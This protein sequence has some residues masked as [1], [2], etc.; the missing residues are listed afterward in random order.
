MSAACS[1]ARLPLADRFSA[2]L[3]GVH[4]EAIPVP[5]V[6]PMGFPDTDFLDA[7]ARAERPAQ[8]RNRGG[9]RCPRD[10]RRRFVLRVAGNG[11]RLGRQCR[12]RADV[13]ARA[14]AT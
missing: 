9:V 5:Y 6:T 10:A 4:A 3:I 14:A 12:Q 8:R 13:A 1:I 7:S 11:E 2:H